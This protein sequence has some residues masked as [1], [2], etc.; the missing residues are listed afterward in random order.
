MPGSG[1]LVVGVVGGDTNEKLTVGPNDPSAAS[2]EEIGQD[3]GSK[4]RWYQLTGKRAGNVMVEVR[5]GDQ[6]VLDYFQLAIK[7][8]PAV[9]LPRA[10][11]TMDFEFEPDD[12]TKPGQINMRVYTPLNEPDYVENRLSGVGFGIYLFGCHLYCTG[13]SLPVFLPDSDIELLWQMR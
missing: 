11:S 5:G 6:S 3:S 13:L 2:V 4:I 1:V 12:P 8:P 10:S 9:N 7:N